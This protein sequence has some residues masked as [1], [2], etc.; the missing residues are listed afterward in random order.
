MSDLYSAYKDKFTIAE[1]KKLVAESLSILRQAKKKTQKE[2][3]EAIGINV[4]TY[5][6]YERGRN[7]TPAEILVRL[8]LYYDVSLD[9][10]MQK[11]NFAKSSY[12]IMEQF[13]AMEK[14]LQTFREKLFN[15]DKQAQGEF[16]AISEGLLALTQAIKDTHDIGLYE[17]KKNESDTD[18]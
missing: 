7:E 16:K 14:E 2:V 1:R 4:Q 12:N 6:S 3:A 13:S 8:S 17:A 5:S 9:V 15:G 10:I 18:D 11:E